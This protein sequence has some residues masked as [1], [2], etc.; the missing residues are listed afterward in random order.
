M[1]DRHS[2]VMGGPRDDDV[3]GDFS[4][5]T[6]E[7]PG[8]GE[9]SSSGY[10]SRGRYTIA[11]LNGWLQR[12]GYTAGPPEITDRAAVLL[13][14]VAGGVEIGGGHYNPR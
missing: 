14:M 5:T 4:S 12:S 10:Y 2:L 8:D 9:G 13:V 3:K 7:R 1:Y 6:S 11:S